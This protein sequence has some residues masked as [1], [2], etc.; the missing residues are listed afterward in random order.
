MEGKTN[1]SRRL[2]RF[3]GFTRL[4]LTSSHI[5]RLIYIRHCH[6]AEAAQSARK[7]A[8]TGVCV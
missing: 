3:D 8:L 5:K 7:Y 4:T 6:C 1:F 2:K